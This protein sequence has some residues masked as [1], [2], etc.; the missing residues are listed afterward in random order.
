MLYQS[1]YNDLVEG[2]LSKSKLALHRK[3]KSDPW[4]YCRFVL[5]EDFEIDAI[6]SIRKATT[7]VN[8][9]ERFAITFVSL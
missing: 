2:R 3:V 4:R 7:L 1:F 8:E 9:D 6:M 5:T